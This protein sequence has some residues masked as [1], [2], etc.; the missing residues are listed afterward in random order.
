MVYGG[1]ELPIRILKDMIRFL[2]KTGL[3]TIAHLRDSK[4]DD[5]L[6]GTPPLGWEQERV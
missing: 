6:A 2:D 1:P 4:V 5:I 3:D